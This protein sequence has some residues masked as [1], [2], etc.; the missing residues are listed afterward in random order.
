LPIQDN[1]LWAFANV[2]I[3]SFS[4][5]T[6]S[7]RCADRFIAWHHHLCESYSGLHCPR[8]SLPICG[9]ANNWSS[10]QY[11]DTQLYDN[12]TIKLTPLLTSHRW[13]S[14]QSHRN[15][16]VI[17]WGKSK[18]VVAKRCEIAG[19]SYQQHPDIGSSHL[20]R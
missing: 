3:F 8:G 20:M 11:R 1:P 6:P 19:R 5:C 15:M 16:R 13:L 12:W 7:H 17:S 18:S 4:F 10:K 14:N 2:S 9:S